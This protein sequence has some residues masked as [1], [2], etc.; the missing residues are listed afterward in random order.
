MGVASII[1]IIPITL[2][3]VQRI[4]MAKIVNLPTTANNNHVKM[5]Q[6]AEMT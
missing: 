2:V 3:T 6:L 4:F 5:V 1:L